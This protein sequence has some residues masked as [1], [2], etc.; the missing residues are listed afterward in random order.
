[1]AGDARYL[2]TYFA[3]DVERW[4][5]TVRVHRT[6]RHGRVEL[7]RTLVREAP[8]H[9]VAIL[10]ASAGFEERYVDLIA[11]AAIARRGR[12]VLLLDATWEPGSRA[13]TPGRRTQAADVVPTMGR[14]AIRAAIR[15]LDHP[16][17]HY[18]VFS[19]GELRTFPET[20][21]VPPDRVHFLPYWGRPSP[22]GDV[23]G[24]PRVFAG[25][26]SLRDYRALLQIAGDVPAPITVATRLPLPP[27]LPENV[28]AGPLE[29]DAFARAAREATIAVVPMLAGAVRSAGHRTYIDAMLAE[30]AVVV[31]DSLGV[32]D[33]V[34]D[35]GT[36]LVVPPDDPRAMAA[37]VRRLL[38][39]PGLAGRLSLTR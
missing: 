22:R 2:S 24:G 13:L 31:T 11:A 15:A 26:D 9:D 16:L 39:E 4:H 8:A 33:H 5:R 12:P 1:M 14:R 36:A 6:D 30:Q 37:A 3:P 23:A 18:V 17:I 25:G 38:T 27:A 7:L 10:R 21:S 19:T 29:P 28:D 34:R 35:G 20:W 32:R